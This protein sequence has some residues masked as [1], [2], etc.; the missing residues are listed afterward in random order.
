MMGRELAWLALSTQLLLVGACSGSDDGGGGDGDPGAP[1]P[2][3]S[4][5]TEKSGGTDVVPHE[6]HT[7]TITIVGASEAVPVANRSFT[8]L[9]EAVN[10]GD[11]FV[12]CSYYPSGDADYPPY[13]EV[14]AGIEG[15]EFYQ[16][17]MQVFRVPTGEE[18]ELLREPDATIEDG[19]Q[20]M[21]LFASLTHDV[22]EGAYRYW[23][24]VDDYA[25]P[26][27]GSSC[28][29]QM[30][31]VV[32]GQLKGTA[33]CVELFPTPGS[34][35]FPVT[36]AP[37]PQARVSLQ[38]DCPLVDRDPGGGIIGSE[39]DGSCVGS[40]SPCILEDAFTCSLIAGCSPSGTCSG[41]ARECD[42]YPT[43]E[44]CEHQSGCQWS[45]FSCGGFSKSCY[46]L[47]D[48]LSCLLQS[49]C[50]WDDRCEGEAVGCSAF[51]TQATC[52]LQGCTWEV[53]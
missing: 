50:E 14:L 9:R 49:G 39:P 8:G 37:S 52:E 40:P 32:E 6:A 3:V 23:Y 27:Y 15:N 13:I 4:P 48:D 43:G 41:S 30:S 36:N 42:F 22:E 11:E 34:P 28:T 47:E 35:D 2:S 17:Q 31:G 25:Y 1:G 29:V 26:P 24:G 45:G 5:T 19:T 7:G 10:P 33:E 16:A 53:Q 38:F 21:I 46:S 20:E 18:Q 51:G 44:L 12:R